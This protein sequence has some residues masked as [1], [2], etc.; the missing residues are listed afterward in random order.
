[1]KQSGRFTGCYVPLNLGEFSW[2][3]GGTAEGLSIPL[4]LSALTSFLEHGLWVKLLTV[5]GT[6]ARSAE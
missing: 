2:P 6:S 5:R 1:M 3:Q 4:R